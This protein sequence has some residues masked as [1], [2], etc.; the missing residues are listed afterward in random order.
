MADTESNSVS[1]ADGTADAEPASEFEPLTRATRPLGRTQRA[2]AALLRRRD[3]ALVFGVVAAGYLVAYLIAIGRL[4]PGRGDVG[5]LVVSDLS[6][7]FRRTGAFSFEPIARLDLGA[8]TLLFS[9]LDTLLGLAL[10]TLVGLNLAL[11][12]LA[13][14]QPVACGIEGASGALAAIPALL[15]GT[16]CCGPVLLLVLGV[17]ASGLLLAVFDVLLPVASIMLLGSLVLVGRN[18]DP[19]LL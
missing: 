8:L 7:A 4:V 15:S 19:T 9:P 6:I 16:A 12:Y 18:V 11:F 1:D 10:A 13:W 14:T 3:A 2:I 5:A 17:Q